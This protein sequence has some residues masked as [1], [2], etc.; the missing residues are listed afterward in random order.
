MAKLKKRDLKKALKEL[1]FEA[2]P[3][4]TNKGR[5][6]LRD[7]CSNKRTPKQKRHQGWRTA[8]WSEKGKYKKEIEEGN[9]S[10]Y[11]YDEWRS[12]H[13]G[14]P[15]YESYDDL[16]RYR[17]GVFDKDNSE[18]MKKQNQKIKKLAQIRRIRRGFKIS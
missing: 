2:A 6:I 15:N 5:H 14:L 4:S 3:L 7:H 8:R 11:F 10:I 12:I 9:D 16:T 17:R 13:D 1:M 18:D